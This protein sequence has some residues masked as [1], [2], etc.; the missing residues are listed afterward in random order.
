MKIKRR[1]KQSLDPQMMRRS[2]KR[3]NKQLYRMIQVMVMIG[4]LV[5]ANVLFTMVTKTHFW[6]GESALNLKI[7][8]SIVDTVVEAQRGTIYDR[9]RNVIAQEVKAW[10][11][12]AYLDSSIEDEEGNPD[13]VKNAASTAKKLCK[14]LKD[15]DEENIEKIIKNAQNKE[16][17][18]TELGAGT[19]RLDEDTMKAVQELDLPGIGFIET[20]NRNYPT[21]PFSS[22]LIGF[23]TYDE[24]EQ[25]IVGKMGLEQTM[26]DI[27]SGKDGRVQYQQA[28]DGS[29]LPGTTKVYEEAEDGD[30]VVL[31]IDYDLQVAVEKSMEETIENNK[32]TSAWAVV[33]EVETGK[34]LAWAS[35]PTFDQNK[36]EEIPSYNDYVSMVAYEPGSVMK[37][38]TYAA[39][40][41]TGTFPENTMYRAGTFTYTF[42]TSTGRIMR[43][44]NGTDTGYPAISDAMGNDFG[45]LTFED[46]LAF[47][48]NVGIC[49]LLANHMNYGSLEDYLDSFGFFQETGIPYVTEATGTKNIDIPTDY[50]STGFGQASSITVLQ[51]MQAYSAIFNEGTMVQ[52]YVVD[53]IED[54]ETGETIESYTTKEVGTPISSETANKMTEM[55]K[56]VLDEGKSGD[57]FAIEGVSMA[58]KTGTGEI[59]N[60][61]TGKYDEVN[62]TSSIMAAA[63]AEDAKIMVYWGMIGPNYVNY[64]AE[65]FQ[66]IMK[67]ALVAYGISGSDESSSSSSA[68]DEESQTWETYT[69]PNLVNHSVDYA[70]SK[71]SGW[72]ATTVMI[73]NGSTIIEQYPASGSV[74]S[75][76]DRVFLLTDGAQITMPDMTGW[77]RKD[78]T[79][80]WD[81][82]G[83]QIQTDGYGTVVAQSVEPNTPIDSS[84][85]ISVTME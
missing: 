20:S 36:H 29:I 49:E 38:F 12:V 5:V 68:E 80:F 24:D 27:L 83:I 45:T 9:N 46:G 47:S 51:L 28:V 2:I 6:S 13:Y 26:N 11:I 19:K 66:D 21:T 82:T 72:K 7:S 30:D 17:S 42:D 41:D 34:I 78:I 65:Q 54:S 85:E 25:K 18:Q 58:A 35:Y 4:T 69:M 43:V 63:P 60:P 84:M 71:T 75:S 37:T 23:A 14:V 40:V 15:A 48:S 57:R 8:S 73:G 81:L 79:A 22:N 32:A 3:S 1:K 64:S 53:S 39:A 59:Y 52:P 10:T 77:T 67:A 56:H 33:M 55:L 76:G 44:S 16:L 74:V 31:T 62:Y 70:N 50:L 61:E